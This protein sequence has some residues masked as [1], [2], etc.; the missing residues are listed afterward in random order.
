M[1]VMIHESGDMVLL[2]ELTDNDTNAADDGIVDLLDVSTA[3]KPLRYFNGEW[4]EI[5]SA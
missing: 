2:K 5:E 3:D 1:F 4:E